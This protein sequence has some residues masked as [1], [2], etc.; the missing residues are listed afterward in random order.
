M[1]MFQPRQ[2]QHR[3]G[4]QRG[5]PSQGTP[6]FTAGERHSQVTAQHTPRTS[7]GAESKVCKVQLASPARGR[8]PGP[9]RSILQ[10]PRNREGEQKS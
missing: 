8:V 2:A 7:Q 6:A 1:S 10:A 4:M 9:T 5:G 3:M